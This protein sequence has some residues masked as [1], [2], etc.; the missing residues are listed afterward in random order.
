MAEIIVSI[1][2][3]I[4]IGFLLAIPA[5]T[6]GYWLGKTGKAP[7]RSLASLFFCLVMS[8]VNQFLFTGAPFKWFALLTIAGSTLGVYRMDLYWTSKDV[9]KQTN[10]DGDSKP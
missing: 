10:S 2:I 6:L 3:S 9:N 4:G 8:L 5:L 7:N 1:L